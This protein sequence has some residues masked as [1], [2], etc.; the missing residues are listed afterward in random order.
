MRYDR[1]FKYYIIYLLTNNING[2][3][4][5][6][7]HG[8]DNLE[9]DYMG[10]GVAIREAIKEYGKKNFSKEILCYCVDRKDACQKEIEY[11]EKLDTTHNGYN[12][13]KGGEGLLG[14]RQK[15][16]S[17]QRMVLSRKRFYQDHPEAK[18]KL[19]H[20]RYG[21]ANPFFG[22]KLSKEHIAL[23]TRTRIAA[24]TGDNN[25]S[26]KRVVCVETGEVFG[27]AKAGARKMGNRND[28]SQIIKVCRGRL[29]T[30]HG[31]H[32]EY[33]D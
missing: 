15:T 8:T 4:Y 17:I 1:T 22:H 7:Q 27:N 19:G 21:E 20:P 12:I 18:A 3:M 13:T 24:I 32:W 2:K 10:S 31:Y 16:E 6:G 26:A 5:V 33:K 29:K 11:I 14:Y 28:P 25:P 23:L 9:D 30:A